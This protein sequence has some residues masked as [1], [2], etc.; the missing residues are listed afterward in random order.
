MARE[1]NLRKLLNER[2]PEEIDDVIDEETCRPTHTSAPRVE[3]SG[4]KYERSLK[5]KKLRAQ[6]AK[7]R[8][9]KYQQPE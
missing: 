5:D 4:K 7:A 1:P 6:R 2:D 8:E 9:Q 3:R